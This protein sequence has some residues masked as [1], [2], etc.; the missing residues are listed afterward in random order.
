MPFIL[1]FKIT[2]MTRK[3]LAKFQEAN[4][5]F[6]PLLKKQLWIF[7]A[8][9]YLSWTFSLCLYCFG[10]YGKFLTKLWE[11]V[12]CAEDAYCVVS[13]MQPKGFGFLTFCQMDRLICCI[14]TCYKPTAK[15]PGPQ[16]LL[17][18]W[19]RCPWANTKLCIQASNMAYSN[20]CL[21]QRQHIK[22][23]PEASKNNIY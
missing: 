16:I 14:G 11:I 6:P 19:A 21:D 10:I 8:I 7:S 9:N 5:I 20:F 2:C 13:K 23:R 17:V 3:Y 22:T 15:K 12:Y 4:M 1:I 18:A